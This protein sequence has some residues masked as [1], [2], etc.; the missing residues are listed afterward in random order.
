MDFVIEGQKCICRYYGLF[1]SKKKSQ[2]YIID[3]YLICN[4][5]TLRLLTLFCIDCC[6][7]SDNNIC[8]Y[9]IYSRL[10]LLKN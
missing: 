5:I 6:I 10:L 7:I 3:D 4:F 8:L 9:L 2:I 1:I